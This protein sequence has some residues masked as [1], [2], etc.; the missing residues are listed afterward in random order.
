M[1]IKH[2]CSTFLDWSG[3]SLWRFVVLLCFEC[4]ISLLVEDI[5]KSRISHKYWT[6]FEKSEK[7]CIRRIFEAQRNVS[8][9]RNTTILGKD[10]INLARHHRSIWWQLS[11]LPI[12]ILDDGKPWRRRIKKGIDSNDRPVYSRFCKK[13]RHVYLR[14]GSFWW[15]HTGW[16]ETR[17]GT[18]NMLHWWNSRFEL[19][20]PSIYF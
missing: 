11:G 20:F 1:V 9:H 12:Q 13:E 18:F 14:F 10:G 17:N 16:K 8:E 4:W 15:R 6:Y 3:A 2:N 5:R 19:I 7:F